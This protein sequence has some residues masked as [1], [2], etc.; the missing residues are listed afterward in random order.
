M[1]DV[2]VILVSSA[3]ALCSLGGVALVQP[4]EIRTSISTS[5]AV[6][7][8]TTKARVDTSDLVLPVL[9]KVGKVK[10]IV[11]ALRNC[12]MKDECLGT[13]QDL[14]YRPDLENE[15]MVK[16][17]SQQGLLSAQEQRCQPRQYRL[18][19][20]DGDGDGNVPVVWTKGSARLTSV[21]ASA[22][23]TGWPHWRASERAR[24]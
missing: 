15:S 20:F 7:L 24:N 23:A 8:N 14:I 6:E 12:A 17:V 3:K 13:R 2:T 19:L 1:S 9:S 16:V 18:V 4:T 22:Q 11:R 5:S 10:L 21:R